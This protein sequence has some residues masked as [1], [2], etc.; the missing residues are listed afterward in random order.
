MTIS[1]T[2]VALVLVACVAAAAPAS[3]DGAW[4]Q[5]PTATFSDGSA[6]YFASSCATGELC[7]RFVE[8]GG[9]ELD[10]YNAGS[11]DCFTPKIQ[12]VRRSGGHEV[13]SSSI[14]TTGTTALPSSREGRVGC[15]AF[16]NTVL[17]LDGGRVLYG[18][19]ARRST[20]LFFE[21]Q[22]VPVSSN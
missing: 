16:A 8:K 1:R 20:A 17:T 18:V 7:A 11:T 6:G 12:M 21:Y 15:L 10:F 5:Q 13:F 3:A 22:E 19:F 4:Q 9:D 14:K 2:I